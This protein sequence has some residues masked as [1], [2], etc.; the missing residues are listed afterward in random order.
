MVEKKDNVKIIDHSKT[1]TYKYLVA[2]ST[3]PADDSLESFFASDRD[4]F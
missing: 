2:L 1:A 4:K 3:R